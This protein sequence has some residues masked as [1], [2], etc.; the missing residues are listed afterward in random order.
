MNK[1]DLGKKAQGEGGETVLGARDLST[2]SI[3]LIY[4]ILKKGD[5][6]RKLRP[7]RGHEEIICVA[8]GSMTLSG[9]EDSQELGEGEAIYLKGEESFMAEAVTDVCVY[10]AAGGH[11][12]G[13]EHHH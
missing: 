3:Y 13:G 5:P 10:V 11:S 7:G 1:Y 8:T 9:G 6:A 4:G 2:H 12:P